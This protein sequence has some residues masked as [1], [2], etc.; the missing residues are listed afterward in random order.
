MVALLDRIRR[1]PPADPALLLPL[2]IEYRVVEIQEPLLVGRP[3][4]VVPARERT[5]RKRSGGRRTRTARVTERTE[6]S[7]TEELI[8]FRATTHSVP[9]MW[10]RWFPDDAFSA[11]DPAVPS[12]EEELALARYRTATAVA[13][14]RLGRSVSWFDGSDAQLNGEW[15]RF[16]TEVGFFR[17]VHLLRRSANAAAPAS[18][19]VILGLPAQV[20]VFALKGGALTFLA[21]GSP[22]PDTIR[23]SPDA[24][25]P[26]EWL[27]SFDR[28]VEQGMGARLKGVALEQALKADWLIATGLR[29]GDARPAVE[30]FLSGAMAAGDFE[31]VPQDTPTNNSA[32]DA[33]G[34]ETWVRDPVS[35]LSEVTYLERRPATEPADSDADVLARALG[36]GSTAL[37]GARH[38]NLRGGKDARSMATA[39]LPALTGHFD[40]I[41]QT[42]SVSPGAFR[43]FLSGS[44]SARGPLPVVRCG[45]N[46]YGILP[47]ALPGSLAP[48]T[49]S[50]PPQGD[51]FNFILRFA[52]ATIAANEGRSAALPIVRPG[53]TDQT[54]AMRR[55]LQ[56]L[57]VS[58]RLDV[59]SGVD[60]RVASGI[61]CPLVLGETGAEH[62]PSAYCEELVSQ[63][64]ARL[65]DP[66]ARDPDYPLL[67]RLLRL[68]LE[69]ILKSVPANLRSLSARAALAAAGTATS[70]PAIQELGEWTRAVE[71]LAARPRAALE[72]LM[73]EVL[74]LLDHR[75]DAWQTGLA[76]ARLMA[77][78]TAGQAGLRIGY[79]GMLCSPRAKSATSATD[80]YVQ[81]PS[82]GQAMTAGL[83]RSAAL[84]HSATDGPFRVN[85]SS[86]RVRKALKTLD[87]LRKGLT[88]G[89]ALG[90]H[91]ER[92]L[93][94]QA[95]DVL[96]HE[97]RDQYSIRRGTGAEATKLPLLD[98][99]LLLAN[100]ATIRQ[101]GPP[102]R[103]A[104]AGRLLDELGEQ[105][106]AFTDVV[107]S[108]AV[109][110]LAHGSPGGVTAWMKVLSGA[111]PPP[112]S[113]FLN[114]HR[115]GHGSSYRVI[116]ASS[117]ATYGGSNPRSIAEPLLAQ[118]A[119]AFAAGFAR[120]TL[121]V[122]LTVPGEAT[123]HTLVVG[124][125]GDLAME[126]IDLLIGGRGE[127]IARTRAHVLAE[128]QKRRSPLRD[129]L[130]ELPETDL[131]G[132]FNQTRPLAIDFAHSV[133]GAPTVDTLLQ[134]LVPL[135]Q[136]VA[137]ARALSPA[138]LNAASAVAA[139]G[140][141]VATM[142]AR[143]AK[144]VTALR[145]RAQK[146]QTSVNRDLKNLTRDGDD[147]VTRAREVRRRDM[148]PEAPGTR[149]RP[150]EMAALQAAKLK[151]ERQL[152]GFAAFGMVDA[153]T[154]YTIQDV[155]AAPD[156]Y[157][158]FLRALRRQ[159]VEKDEALSGAL[160]AA[161]AV[162]ASTRAI[163][164][165]LT[166]GIQ[167]ACGGDAIKVWPPCDV[168]ADTTPDVGA[169]KPLA[170]AFGNW[171]QVRP[172]LRPAL[173]LQNV[174]PNVAARVTARAATSDP[175]RPAISYSG[176]H[177]LPTGNLPNNTAAGFVVDEWNDFRPSS[178]QTTGL[179]INYDSPQSEPAHV[180]LLGVAPNDGVT[181]WS[182]A[183]AAGLVQEAIRLM[184]VRPL[185][186]QESSVS[187]LGLKTMN[188]IPPIMEGRQ[189]RERIPGRR[190]VVK[191]Q[192]NKLFGWRMIDGRPNVLNTARGI[193]ERDPGENGS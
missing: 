99:E 15:E 134:R 71:W 49:S 102:A 174:L 132:F 41:L 142:A 136:L 127:V 25:A 70:D 94:E 21:Q 125:S 160:T 86:R 162:G 186:S 115:A 89:E 148:I 28:A 152:P 175:R 66:D 24:L 60:P 87:V 65:A 159:L 39:L 112:E 105:M 32:R 20:S 137:R 98:G 193:I 27:T 168:Q 78:R 34:F 2:R 73:L 29:P 157:E 10:V 120:A 149:D 76:T 178:I 103:R 158:A 72:T 128:W 62:A 16:T 11:Q 107:V 163:I 17:A 63:P 156:G 88:L 189:G 169:P 74:D 52:G 135:G 35:T 61:A 177:I 106:D 171:P 121:R 93:H 31:L 154:P 36:I 176:I 161:A 75:V 80:G 190:L 146:L 165:G 155:I 77:Q 81:A 90:Y 38:A 42:E 126:P 111:A 79:Y 114:T 44:A 9:Q 6:R 1:Q 191:A 45:E 51:A 92:W 67:Y 150:S 143:Y 181:T 144:G 119:D 5:A 187:N 141:D 3:L 46:P 140:F 58:P 14:T 124:L 164:D 110:Q 170:D 64:L 18:Q 131:I 13:S 26:G 173:E 139:D 43:S 122:S 133:R 69:R 130:G 40:P 129:A 184:R 57:P 113:V 104:A 192:P 145:D 22:I 147:V 12:P 151:L 54:E 116:Y 101:A 179:A 56:M 33:A 50:T 83:L 108:E 91:A 188:I 23:Y 185:P 47:I 30:R 172:G 96:L 109:H 118:L 95:L 53:M 19:P 182:E 7:S 55:I 85:L 8:R 59:T 183:H 68:S 84:R 117:P 100:A 82:V 180:L 123:S 97:L 37:Y 153:L 166:V 48:A 4:A 138:D 167:Q